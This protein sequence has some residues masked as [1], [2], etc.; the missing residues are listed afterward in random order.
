MVSGKEEISSLNEVSSLFA[1]KRF[2]KGSILLQQSEKCQYCYQV[3]SGCL[4]SFVIDSSAKEH[5]IQFAPENWLITDMNSFLNDVTSVVNIDVIEDSEVIVYDKRALGYLERLSKEI[6][7]SEITRLHKNVISH[8]N[9]IISLLR[10]TG[11]ERYMS[12]IDTYP[13]LY[14]RLPLKQI[15][16]YLGIT[17]EYLSRIRKKLVQK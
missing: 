15:A 6:L 12:F 1:V 5:V 3:R 7:L 17:P 8:H 2:P 14:S 13:S 10:S 9:R 16:S 11:E 4:R